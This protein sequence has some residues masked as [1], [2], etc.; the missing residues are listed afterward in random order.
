MS[1]SKSQKIAEKTIFATFK[2]LK[3]AGGEM[4]G[5]DVVDKIRETVEF[6]EYESHRYEKTGYIRWESI[7]H[8][9]TIDCMKAGFLR[10]HKG[11]WILTDEGEK[12]MKL[13]AEK[14]METASK[15][16]REWDGKRKQETV[17]EDIEDFKEED[18]GQVQKSIISQYEDEAFNGI[19]NY[20]ISK[21]PYEFQDLVAELLRAMGYHISD[22][23]QRGPDGGI[24]II[25]YTDPL[26]TRQPRIIVQVKHR[27]NDNVSSDEV[28]KLAGTLKRNSDVGIFVT[29]GSFSK[30][31]IKEARESREHIEL[32]DFERLTS[33]WQEYYSKMNDE[34]KN[35]LPL[36]PI[37]FLG[38]ND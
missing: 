7:L 24:D 9:Y 2:I 11:T 8:F 4:R 22:V 23:A 28:Q 16:Y 29:S 12:A 13:G 3:E 14:L 31:A 30:P 10:K 5:K 33:L 37:Y 18:S 20:I 26:G 15:L 35:L 38:S 19:R 1:K 6:D 25:A 36:H 17:E 27:P 34:Q 21:N 32:I